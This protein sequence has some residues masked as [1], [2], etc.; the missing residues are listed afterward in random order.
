[1][2]FS[3]FYELQI[4]DPTPEREVSAFH[5]VLEQAVLADALGYDCLWAVEHHGLHEYSH[6]SAPEI[7][8]SFVAAKT[9]RLRVGHGVTLLPYR[10]N[11]PIRVA[12]RVAT[13]DI[14]SGGRVNLGTGKS[15]SSVE[16]QAFGCDVGELHAQWREALG[17]LPAIWQSDVFEFEGRFFKVAPTRIVPKP[18]QQPHPPLYAACTRTQ[19]VELAAAL[20]LGALCFALGKRNELAGMVETYRAHAARAQPVGA[21]ATSH[22]ACTPATLVLDDDLVACRYGMRGARFFAD[23]LNHYYYSGERAAGALRARRGFLDESALRAA[24]KR[25]NGPEDTYNVLVGDPVFAREYVSS[26][27][28]LGVDELILVMQMG[29]VPSHLVRQSITV[30]GEKVLPYF[31]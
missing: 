11:H 5:D 27:R 26:F 20:G 28:D 13:L 1:M 4:S 3:L 29:T 6:C 30:F 18:V 14:L 7:L 8:L 10:Y 23:A 2:R 16:Q 19:S 17:M 15:A 21:F 12:E 9:R 25:R 31:G 24:R 22:F